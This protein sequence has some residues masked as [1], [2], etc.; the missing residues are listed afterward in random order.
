MLI[1]R[2]TLFG[3]PSRAQATISPDGRWLSWLAPHKEVLNVW[4]APVDDLAAAHCI[5]RDRRRGIQFHMWTHDRAHVL[6]I[7]DRDGDENWHVF[8]VDVGSGAERDLTPV[9]GVHATLAGASPDRPDTIVIGLNDRD[10]SWHDLYEIDIATA[11]RRLLLRNEDELSGFVLDRELRVRL[12]ARELP[13]GERLVLRHASGRFQDMLR[14]PHEDSLGTNFLSCNAAGDAVFAYSSIG[15][16]RT[17]LLRV[18]WA[19]GRQV[20]L[21]EHPKADIDEFL[22]N[23][24]TDEVEAASADHLRREW[25]PVA[26]GEAAYRDLD[27][28]RRRLPGEIAVT[29]QSADNRQWVVH[30]SSPQMPGTY[31][32][33]DRGR[34][35][36]RDLFATR[37]ELAQAP[38]RPMH[39]T[40]IRARDGL[41]LVSYLTLPQGES[42][43]PPKPLPMILLVHGGPWSRNFFGFDPLHQW[44]ADRGYAVLNVNFRGSTG[45]GKAFLNAGD[46]EWGRK[47]QDDLIDAVEWSIAEGIAER[48]RVAI[49]GASY[50]GYATLAAL[51]FTPD[52]FCCGVD[53]V[54]PSNL[55]T[56][57]ATSPAYWASFFEFEA[58]RVGDPR[59][60][61]GR[62]LLRERSPL[63]KA[64][65][66]AKP[67]LIGQGARD[68]RVKQAES[69]QIVAAMRARSLPVT[70][71][72]YA[73]EG[74][75]F[76]RPQS[77][78][79]WFAIAEAFLAAH[80]GGRAEPL[81][82][83]LDG[84]NLEV[85]EG[86]EQ[87]AGLAAA[88]RTVDAPGG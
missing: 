81:G 43:R 76:G 34:Q 9:D 44:L 29:S 26:G 82:Q 60:E 23:P 31:Y 39:A 7:Q 41:E 2:R 40:V 64:H 73:D 27:F 58:R 21:A 59:T 18:D 37:P 25:L 70:Y 15:R 65:A 49:M 79:S 62:A 17:A 51:A 10:A 38:L 77:R 84:A 13:G 52:V 53:R 12:A 8:A 54:G 14:I 16:D 35:S 66:I 85:R 20:V 67:L 30:R 24:V 83:D 5:T 4:V 50:G 75:G 28:L 22:V 19:T 71:V 56:M 6:Y 47:M 45:F 78:L 57:L 55:E 74:H 32:L 33:F 36:L 87:I 80:L 3:D 69:D 72:L 48:D 68:P 63:H 11:D 61:A 46:R 88:L 1:P 86:A 42:A